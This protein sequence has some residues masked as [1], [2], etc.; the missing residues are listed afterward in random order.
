MAWTLWTL[1]LFFH[2]CSKWRSGAVSKQEARADGPGQAEQPSSVSPKVGF[3]FQR[4]RPPREGQD[5]YYTCRNVEYLAPNYPTFM[6]QFNITDVFDQRTDPK[7]MKM[8]C[9]TRVLRGGT[10][11]G[12]MV[13]CYT[14]TNEV[15]KWIVKR[16]EGQGPGIM[17]ATTECGAKRIV[18]DLCT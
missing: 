12:S 11:V 10:S 18:T 17:R 15:S 8:K 7:N 1:S 6:E 14:A 5:I 2:S 16:I 4:I 3:L 13:I 9:S